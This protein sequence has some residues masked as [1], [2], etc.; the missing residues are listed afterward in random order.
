MVK[1][2][3]N[4]KRYSISSAD[5]E[6]RVFRMAIRTALSCLLSI[7]LFQWMGYNTLIGWA[8][9]AALAFQQIDT[10]DLLSRRVIYL[11][12][13]IILFAALALLGISLSTHWI[14]FLATIPVVIF[15]C[16]YVAA[17]GPQYF[18][19]GG[20]AGFLY[21]AFGSS[22]GSK[23]YAVHVA[24][25]FL[26]IGILCLCISILVF[27]ERPLQ[28]ILTS[29]RRVF[30]KMRGNHHH[31]LQTALALHNNTIEIYLKAAQLSVTQHETCLAMQKAMYQTFLMLA[32]LKILHK[33]ASLHVTFAQTELEVCDH[34][35]QRMIKLL[36]RGDPIPPYSKKVETYRARIKAIQLQELEKLEPN[37]APL[38]EYSSYLY[39]YIQLWQTLVVISLQYKQLQGDV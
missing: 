5:P 39:H 30:A 14:I 33:K 36:L 19:A 25:T 15:I 10:L 11:V 13:N 9:F 20:W 38:L 35:T 16:G 7:L 34:D 22:I 18:N 3:S 1:I 2:F 26:V 29:T 37:F 23:F 4:F 28:R 31:S 32:Q 6:G 8:A 24:L 21:V 17:F 12:A 27:P